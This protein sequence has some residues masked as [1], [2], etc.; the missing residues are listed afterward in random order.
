MRAVLKKIR[1]FRFL[2][3][4][5]SRRCIVC[6]ELVPY[7]M[8]HSL[9]EGC[10]TDIKN[11][12][13]ARC[14][15]CSRPVG[16]GNICKICRRG[17]NHFD[18]GYSVFPYKGNVRK[19]LLEMKYK[20]RP[21]LYTFFEEYAKKELPREEYDIYTFVPIHRNR[22]VQR[23]YNQAEIICES[24]FEKCDNLLIRN[25]D[26]APQH[27]LSEEQREKNIKNAFSLREGLN[28]EGKKILLVD[29]ILTSG[30][31]ANECAKILKKAKAKRVDIFVLCAVEDD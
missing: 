13:G 11:Y 31:T 14:D 9:C 6:R 7:H 23:G 26:T 8:E 4:V 25:K 24:L 3:L 22:Y 27:N 17:K 19:V 2:D 18:K 5:F 29:D 16:A 20:D 15:I 21:D 28:L 12:T 30:A 10:V 1:S